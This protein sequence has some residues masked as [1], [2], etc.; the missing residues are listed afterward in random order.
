MLFEIKS[1]SK[2]LEKLKI[3]INGVIGDPTGNVELANLSSHNWIHDDI[4]V[5]ANFI[6]NTNSLKIV[7]RK[8]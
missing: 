8:I 4:E 3:S 2:K 5:S 6:T 1:D 7:I